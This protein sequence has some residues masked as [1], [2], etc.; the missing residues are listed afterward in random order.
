M[1]FVALT[2]RLVERILWG[3]EA[4]RF[5]TTCSP[6]LPVIRGLVYLDIDGPRTTTG[7]LPSTATTISVE[8]DDQLWLHDLRFRCPS[9]QL[10]LQQH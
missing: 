6:F 3:V 9:K 7:V 1:V 4:G 10:F 5:S 8:G 2:L